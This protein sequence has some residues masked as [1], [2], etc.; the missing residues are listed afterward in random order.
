MSLLDLVK[1]IF[2]KP[3]LPQKRYVVIFFLA[4]YPLLHLYVEHTQ[5]DW[6]NK[7]LEAVKSV[8]LASFSE[9]D[10]PSDHYD[11]NG[12]RFGERD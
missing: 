7:A 1:K 2:P 8:V 3:Q 6:D 5:A 11:D 10:A 4:A 9:P 12:M